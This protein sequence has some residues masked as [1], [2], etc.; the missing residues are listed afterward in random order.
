MAARAALSR[1]NNEPCTA[2]N[3][4]FFPRLPID[5]IEMMRTT[6]GEHFYIV[7]FQDSDEADRKCA[8]DPARVFEVMMRKGAVTRE[9]FN[10]L[11]PA[12][13]SFSILAALERTELAGDALLSDEEARVYID[14]FA[15]GGF[16]GP[17]NYYRNWTH[18]WET[19]ANVEQ[20]ITVPSL[21]IGAVNDVI[22][23]PEQI[24]AMQPHVNDLEM[25]MLDNCGHWSQQ[26][27]P[28]EVNALLLDWLARH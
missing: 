20:Q 9:H 3:I 21:F 7:N 24:A 5:P 22:I 27:K 11:P 1:S 15:A 19:A 6:L 10:S 26:E 4:P 25:H 18:N 12:M 8:A 28:D 23:S 14:A 17:I 16:T 13:R 2:L